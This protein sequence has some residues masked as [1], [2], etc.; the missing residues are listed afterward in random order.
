MIK[1]I[2]ASFLVVKIQAPPLNSFS[3]LNEVFIEFSIK[4]S[5]IAKGLIIDL[6]T[7][8]FNFTDL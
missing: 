6:S 7:E 2:G 4:K 3:K 5:F 8:I 1:I